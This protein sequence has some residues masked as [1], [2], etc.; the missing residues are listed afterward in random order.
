MSPYLFL[1]PDGAGFFGCSLL[2]GGGTAL[3]IKR[4]NFNVPAGTFLTEYLFDCVIGRG[5]LTDR[6]VYYFYGHIPP[7]CDDVAHRMSFQLW[8]FEYPILGRDSAG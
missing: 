8:A 2:L 7:D 4:S 6:L 3:Q 5:I 1:G